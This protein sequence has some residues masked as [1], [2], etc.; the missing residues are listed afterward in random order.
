[1]QSL[2][3]TSVVSQWY[4]QPS[5]LPPLEISCNQTMGTIIA[6]TLILVI[7]TWSGDMDVRVVQKQTVGHTVQHVE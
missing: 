1:M 5:P 6:A 7:P 2:D 3:S 4:I